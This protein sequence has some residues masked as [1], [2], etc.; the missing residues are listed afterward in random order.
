MPAPFRLAAVPTAMLVL[1]LQVCSSESARPAGDTAE[2]IDLFNG[3]DLDGWVPKIAGYELGE[4]FANTFRVQDGLL[5]VRYDGYE[6][7]DE[8]FGHLFFETPFSH[9]RLV[10]EYRFVGEQATGGQGWARRNSGVM[11]HAQDPATMARDQDFPIS[12]EVQF[13]GGLGEGSRPTGNVCTPGTEI[14][15]DGEMARDHCIEST[16]PTFDGDQW[17]RSET[18]VRGDSLFVH[19]VNGDTVLQ[20]TGPTV[21]GGVVNRYDPA[22]KVDGTP[23]TSGFIALQSESHPIDFRLVRLLDLTGR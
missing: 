18:I 16:S 20:Y 4:N 21:G 1:G 2:W 10:V 15:L 22:A 23:L 17:V 14:I 3:R 11:L 5:Q 13:L 19:L 6:Q 9:Y 12:V 8:Q 7:F